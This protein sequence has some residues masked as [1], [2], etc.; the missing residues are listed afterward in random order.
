MGWE[1]IRDV[2]LI[3]HLAKSKP[4]HEKPEAINLGFLLST[5]GVEVFSIVRFPAN[6]VLTTLFALLG[7]ISPIIEFL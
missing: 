4:S 2:A 6:H 3:L 1:R 7:N 5:I